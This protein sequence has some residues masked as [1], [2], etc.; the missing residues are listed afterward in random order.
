MMVR[1][2]VSQCLFAYIIGAGTAELGWYRELKSRPFVGAGLFL[3][4]DAIKFC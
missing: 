3:F 1:C 4:A 2:R